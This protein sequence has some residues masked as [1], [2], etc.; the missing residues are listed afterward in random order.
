MKT[1]KDFPFQR[2]IIVAYRLPFK[3]IKKKEGCFAYQNTGGLVSAILSLSTK[4]QV[5]ESTGE[6][7]KII[8]VGEGKEV[9][10]KI[11]NKQNISETFDLVSVHIP[12][13]INEKY[14]GGFC[15]NMIW[16]L[17]HYFPSLANYDKSYFPA[18]VHANNL[19]Y[20]QLRTIIR[21][22][23]FIWIHDYQLFLLPDLIRKD[24]PDQAIGFFLHIPF[25][26]FEIFRLMPRT[27]YTMILRGM[28]GADLVGFHTEDYARYFIH[29]VEQSLGY[30]HRKNIIKLEGRFVKAGA[31]P[32]GIDFE[33]FHHAALS[34]KVGKERQRIQHRKKNKK[35]VVSV[36]RLDYSKG[37]INRLRGIEYFLEKN[38]E[39]HEKVIFNLVVVPSRDT[40]E[41]YRTM[42]KEIEATVGRVNG[43]YS[44]IGWRPLIYQYRSLS[45]Q[46]LVALY[47][48]SDVGLITP[49]RDGMNLVAKEFVASQVKKDGVLILSEMA[50]ASA[51]LKEAV[52][53]NPFD[54]QEMA[55]SIKLALEMPDDERKSRISKL[56]SRARNYTVFKWADDFFI[57]T[58]KMSKTFL[59]VLL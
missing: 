50:G 25:P 38:P 46:E 12:H 10:D 58:Q 51:E 3:V 30:Q 39:W 20:D 15:N 19:F 34:L 59:N 49:L 42:K 57:Q 44:N 6:M 18:F 41:R 23:D 7:N 4:F 8:W 47:E 45:F 2:L 53:I 9:F 37:L 32:I 43:K 26:C 52:I 55:E 5:T 33:K 35:L 40:L 29:C 16:P 28:L 54:Y 31:F 14:Y 56:Q 48:T 13:K 21:P 11:E 27:W 17:F 36:D 1:K 22:G 24:H